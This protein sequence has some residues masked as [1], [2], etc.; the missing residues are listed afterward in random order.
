MVI[1]WGV[2]RRRLAQRRL[3]LAGLTIGQRMLLAGCLLAGLLAAAAIVLEGRGRYRLPALGSVT[4]GLRTDLHPEQLVVLL[5]AMA[6]A[7]AAGALAIRQQRWWIALPLLALLAGYEMTV[8]LYVLDQLSSLLKVYGEAEGRAQSAVTVLRS[9]ALAAM[10][11]PGCGVVLALLPWRR[12]RAAAPVFF[13][14]P[15]LVLL[16]TW[17]VLNANG[18]SLTGRLDS[19]LPEA[20]PVVRLISMTVNDH[21]LAAAGLAMTVTIWQAVLGA[22]AARDVAGVLGQMGPVGTSAASKIRAGHAAGW[23]VAGL[24]VVKVAWIAAGLRDV[25][26]AILAGENGVWRG[27]RTD[28]WLSWTFAVAAAGLVAWWLWRGAFGPA[29]EGPL[30]GAAAALVV[31]LTVPEIAFQLMSLGYTSGLAGDWAFQ[32]AKWIEVATPWSLPLVGLGAGVAAVVLAA[33]HRAGSAVL[34]LAVFAGWLALRLPL[35]VKD[36]LE[37][38]WYPWDYSLPS[39]LNGQRPGWINIATLDAALTVAL[40]ALAVVAARRHDRRLLTAVVVVTIAGTLMAY[41]AALSGGVL[42]AGV[43]AYVAFVLPIGYQFLFDAQALN[44]PGPRR[45]G[46]VFAVVALATVGLTV[47]VLRGARGA[48][49]AAND[50]AMGGALL[51]VPVVVASVAILLNRRFHSREPEPSPGESVVAGASS[52]PAPPREVT[53]PGR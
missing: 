17:V 30:V 3:S 2:L 48:P 9:G 47:A 6:A 12:A 44:T 34:L 51:S 49:S 22:R 39:E 37:F 28:G 45:V 31:A 25:L 8:P 18:A 42:V 50:L 14:L 21:V 52:E 41:G 43:G 27:L 20:F 36:L 15:F 29:D 24:L 19:R 23:L 53:S 26:P 46:R 33:R 5:L 1:R 7:G 16:G 40:L 38:P 35:L 32:T 13:A 4:V 10:V 11:W